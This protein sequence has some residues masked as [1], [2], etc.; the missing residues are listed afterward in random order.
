MQRSTICCSS[1]L[2]VSRIEVEIACCRWAG[3]QTGFCPRLKHLSR[4]VSNSQ[5]IWSRFTSMWAKARNKIGIV[6]RSTGAL[7]GYRRTDRGDEDAGSDSFSGP[8]GDGRVVS[9]RRWTYHIL[10]E[11]ES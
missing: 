11:A 8:R 2:L 7:R 10:Y 5:T 6:A 3:V 4:S 9:F 1:W